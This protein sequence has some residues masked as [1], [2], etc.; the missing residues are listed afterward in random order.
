MLNT[1]PIV[2]AFFEKAQLALVYGRMV[3]DSSR[4]KSGV[5]IPMEA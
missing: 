5:R 4:L 1:L 3:G 2:Q